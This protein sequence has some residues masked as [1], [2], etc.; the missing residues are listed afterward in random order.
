M[1]INIMETVRK[2]MG[3]CPNISLNHQGTE[4]LNFEFLSTNKGTIPPQFLPLILKNTYVA[5]AG[6]VKEGIIA[7]IFV[8]AVF[9]LS[10]ASGYNS[11][12]YNYGTAIILL[13]VLL[14]QFVVSRAT[15]EINNKNIKVRTMFYQIFGTTTRSLE[16]IRKVQVQSN[17]IYR[18]AYWGLFLV[19]TLWLILFFWSL[20]AGKPLKDL[21]Q[22]LLW[23]VFSFG[24]GYF[25]YMST[26]AVYS[27]Q[28]KFYPHPSINRIQVYTKNAQQI[29]DILNKASK[30][31]NNLNE[32]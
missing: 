9:L 6:M 21:N 2:M 24:Y 7:L 4:N 12:F 18:F 31:Q 8:L 3:W 19:G 11:F 30:N 17:K 27:I 13:S 28:I 26:K 16:S 1:T 22:N 29:A 14:L 25:L 10:V 5:G 32:G 23:V 15:I 20:F